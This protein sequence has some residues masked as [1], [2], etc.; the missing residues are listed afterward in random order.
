ML[1]LLLCGI[2]T[3]AWAQETVKGDPGSEKLIRTIRRGVS[4][5]LW[6]IYE[7]DAYSHKDKDGLYSVETNKKEQLVKGH[8]KDNKKVGV[9]EYYDGGV[10]VQ[11]YD[12]SKD[13]LLFDTTD[14][15][16]FVA[17]QYS[18]EAI[19]DET[20]TVLPPRKIG[21]VN[22]GFLLLFDP[23]DYPPDLKGISSDVKMTYM[24]TISETGKLLKWKV[25]YV[26]PT[27]QEIIQERE[28]NHLP[29]D[30]Y[31]FTAARVNGKPVRSTIVYSVPITVDHRPG[32]GGSNG[33]VTRHSVQE[34]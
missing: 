17:T 6:E 15:N 5:Y 27:V 31:E 22:Y 4:R 3:G 12:F 13:T 19:T 25:M 7:A 34:N 26:G 11:Q 10:L 20:D 16:T 1:L 24:F 2:T 23:R 14:V 9:W 29:A 18:V 30:A 33:N 32:M 8:Y 21:G 28:I